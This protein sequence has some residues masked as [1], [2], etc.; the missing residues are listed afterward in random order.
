MISEKQEEEEE[1]T[2]FEENNTYKKH[3]PSNPGDFKTWINQFL[4]LAFTFLKSQVKHLF[5]I[6]IFTPHAAVETVIPLR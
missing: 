4:V 2:V 3:T 1:K 5:V 6:S